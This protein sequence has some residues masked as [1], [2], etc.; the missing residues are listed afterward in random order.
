[1]R[2]VKISMKFPRL[3]R[4]HLITSLQCPYS[5]LQNLMIQKLK[6]VLG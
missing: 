4:S 3:P 5:V 1:M 6:D 2:S